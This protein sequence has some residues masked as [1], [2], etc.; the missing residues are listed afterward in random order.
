MPYV[1]AIDLQP[2][3]TTVAVQWDTQAP[4]LISPDAAMP[5]I[6]SVVGIAAS[7]ETLI[8]SRAAT[9]AT[10]DPA[11]VS[12]DFVQRIGDPRPIVLAGRPYAAPDVAGLFL[13]SLYVAI[14]QMMRRQPERVV[15][16]HP[17]FYDEYRIRLLEEAAR[18][19]G[20]PGVIVVSE[21]AA[22]SAYGDS[23]AVSTNP[24]ASAF[25]ALAM[26]SGR[27]VAPPPPPPFPSDFP[28][29]APP[30]FPQQPSPWTTGP[31]G[32][33]LLAP[34]EA[35]PFPIPLSPPV[36]RD[37]WLSPALPAPLPAIV[38]ARRRSPLVLAVA[39]AVVIAALVIVIAKSRNGDQRAG[40]RTTA[41][42]PVTPTRPRTTTATSSPPGSRAQP[43]ST[44]PQSTA[45]QG[46]EATAVT[47]PGTAPAGAAMT[48]TLE[49]DP[50]A[51][52]QDGS[53]IGVADFECT[54]R[55][56]LSTPTTVS[57]AGYDKISAVTQGKDAREVVI[58]YTEPF[59]AYRTLFSSL[60]QR[61]AV[62]NCDDVS[63]DFQTTLASSG[64]EW[65]LQSWSDAQEV[66][67]PNDHYWGPKPT[68]ER[69]VIK[70]V[71]DD[72]QAAVTNGDVDYAYQLF[73]DGIAFQPSAGQV[74][75]K[76]GT[77]SQFEALYFNEKDGHPF[78]DP[79]VRQAFYESIDLD[80]FFAQIYA[81]IA[82]GTK[83]L[84][85][86]PV[87]AGPL[88]PTGLFGNRFDLAR[89]AATMTAAGYA[90]NSQ[91]L[92]AKGDTVLEIKWMVSTGNRRRESAQA[93]LIP[94][95][96]SAG[97]EVTA[98]NCDSSCVFQ[99]RLPSLD[100]DL[101]MYTNTT[102]AD[103][104]YLV[105]Q[106]TS[107]NIP[108][109]ANSGLGLN[110]QAWVNEAATKALHD[111]EVQLDP[112]KRVADIKTAITEMDRDTVLIPLYQ[113]PS[114]A[115][116]RTD[117]VDNVDGQIDN[118]YRAFGDVATWKDVDGDG[119]VTIGVNAWPACLN[120]VTSDCA[121]P[122]AYLW[123]VSN[124]ILPGVFDATPTGY[125]KTNLVTAEP[126]ITT[127]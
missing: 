61:S 54:W 89:A 101:T 51:V 119:T 63:G 3:A 48:E 93:Y 13:G 21:T 118:M 94:L 102:T 97:F 88:C 26:V 52:W 76:T 99:D 43:R 46:P 114:L 107:D 34:G 69:V 6:M 116:H 84:T 25:G 105:A 112:A 110:D 66:L 17:G 7:G 2:A 122:F 39:A 123:A 78:A 42:A 16:C 28:S 71:T 49:L 58:S 117:R 90:R 103:P 14:T 27:E 23:Y 50:R 111:S 109:D 12:G 5:T 113:F 79:A 41:P 98:D 127:P 100:Y 44:L 11:R 70:P 120:P 1:L 81:P 96:A 67:V 75:T 104:G 15:L 56:F 36:Q 68:V 91:G 95:L 57:P 82:P 38:P 55:A 87:Q 24:S 33:R 115:S 73:G 80:A 29:D 65:K 10:H 53:P 74:E 59:A 31:S 72:L 83:L 8:G 106:F 30:S 19:S 22:A 9:L 86:G 124:L 40:S 92:W 45:P 32:P 77:T 85:C 126:L 121:T 108:I 62:D 125:V 35:S 64:R 37:P 4:S 47:T 60:I 20:L 18:R